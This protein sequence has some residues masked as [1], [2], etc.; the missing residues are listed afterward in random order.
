MITDKIIWPKHYDHASADINVEAEVAADGVTAEELWPYLTNIS[1]ISKLVREVVDAE[2]ADS[3]VSDPH[4]CAKE[5]FTLDT[6]QYHAVLHVL[7]VI[8][9]KADRAG[10]ITWEGEGRLN[11]SDTTFHIVH[12]WVLDVQKGDRL[13][14]VSAISVVG[15]VLSVNYFSELNQ[16]WLTALVKYT[17]TKL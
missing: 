15:K 12:A 13:N 4:M 16:R 11:N 8:P 6:T 9:P 14:V 1:D 17:R 5:G 3:S 10:R 2:P 7:E